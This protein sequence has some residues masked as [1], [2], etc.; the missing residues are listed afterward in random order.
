MDY[1][2][3]S[4]TLNF[5][6]ASVRRRTSVDSLAAASVKTLRSFPNEIVTCMAKL[7]LVAYYAEQY[8]C[9][10]SSL[11]KP[12]CLYCTLEVLSMSDD[13]CDDDDNNDDMLVGVTAS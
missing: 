5:D 9:Q 1:F 10:G 6:D 2:V 12:T 8:P 13:V 4:L 3:P 11:S 7:Q